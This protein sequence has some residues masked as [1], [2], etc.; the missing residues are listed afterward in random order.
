MHT[1]V[2]LIAGA[3]RKSNRVIK[4]TDALMGL[5][6]AIVCLWTITDIHPLGGIKGF[7]GV[8]ILL[9]S[10]TFLTF[11]RKTPDDC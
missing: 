10:G 4:T 1:L 8:I 5:I 3:S 2:L 7:P 9:E 6:A 11:D